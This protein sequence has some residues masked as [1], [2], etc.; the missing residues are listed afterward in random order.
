MNESS[1]FHDCPNHPTTTLRIFNTTVARNTGMGLLIL[2]ES[3]CTKRNIEIDQVVV[4]ENNSTTQTGLGALVIMET[5]SSGSNPR[6]SMIKVSSTVVTENTGGGVVILIFNNCTTCKCNIEISQVIFLENINSNLSRLGG[7][8]LVFIMGNRVSTT[9]TH[10]LRISNCVFQSGV[11]R[12]GGGAC[13]IGIFTVDMFDNVMNETHEWMSILHSQFIGNTA[14]DGGGLS[15]SVRYSPSIN[16]LFHLNALVSTVRVQNT[17]FTDNVAW[18]GSA[19]SIS[20]FKLN[21]VAAIGLQQFIFEDTSF[22]HNHQS[23]DVLL[24]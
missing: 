17:T 18:F 4:R 13:I 1:Q 16:E 9:P 15:I 12:I 22:Y 19:V 3:K 20:H 11:A 8:F 7:N 21:S 24:L 10:Y 14:L 5:S 23:I 6:Q 2:L